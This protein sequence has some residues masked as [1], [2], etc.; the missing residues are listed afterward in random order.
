MKDSLETSKEQP[1]T[2]RKRNDSV[3]KPTAQNKDPFDMTDVKKFI[4]K[5]LNEIVDL[6]INNNENK[7]Q[8]RGFVRPP[9]RRPYQ[10]PQN[11]PPPDPTEGLSNE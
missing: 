9:F 6:K 5:M 11:P 3:P 4:Q 2:S 1:S 7:N 10:P 8:H